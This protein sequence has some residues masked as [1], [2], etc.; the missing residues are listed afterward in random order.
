MRT[1][2]KLGITIVAMAAWCHAARAE[3]SAPSYAIMS[4]LADHISMVTYQV[5]TGSNRLDSN[6]RKD[7]PLADDSLDGVAAFAADDAIRKLQPAARTQLFVTRDTKVLALQDTALDAAELP[8][9]L[10]E[11]VKG[12][13]AKSNA[14]R[15]VVIARH[16]DETRIQFFDRTLGSGRVSGV[17]FYVDPVSDVLNRDTGRSATGYVGSYAYVKVNVYDMATLR[18]VAEARTKATRVFTAAGSQTA[19]VA[20]EAMS[21]AD[22]F[23]ALKT[24]IREAVAE[25]IPKVVR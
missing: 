14:E 24:V 1:L 9:E 7:I 21:S 6:V 13:V 18:P 10:L 2:L 15:L 19:L 22:K 20:W 4:L 5:G 11:T 25:A 8:A 3:S 17:G 12:L 16:R 23:E